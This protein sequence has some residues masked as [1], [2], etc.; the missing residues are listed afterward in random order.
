MA[1]KIGVL[2]NEEIEI[3]VG[4]PTAMGVRAEEH[5]A[6]WIAGAANP[7]DDFVQELR[8]NGWER[9]GL[10]RRV[11]TSSTTVCES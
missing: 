8:V 6:P 3:T 1:G 7:G 5:H 10:S 9:G 4:P 2:D 11:S